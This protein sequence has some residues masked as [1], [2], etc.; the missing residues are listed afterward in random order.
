MFYNYA[1][2]DIKARI[3]RPKVV[4]LIARYVVALL[5]IVLFLLTK[6]VIVLLIMIGGILG[7]CIWAILKNYRYI[8]KTAALFYLPF[9][10]FISDLAVIHGTLKGAY[11]W[12]IQK[13]R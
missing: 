11:L 10:Q 7:Y 2:S 3:V 13:M 12:V 4:L 5:S 1:Y 8:K 6:S 9:L